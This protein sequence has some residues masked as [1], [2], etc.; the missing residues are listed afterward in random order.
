M[1]STGSDFEIAPVE[2]AAFGI[3]GESD[4]QLLAEV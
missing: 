2:S 4:D 1:T 3:L